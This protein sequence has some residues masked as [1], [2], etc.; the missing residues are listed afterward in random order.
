MNSYD[1]VPNQSANGMMIGFEDCIALTILGFFC[2]AIGIKGLSF[3]VDHDFGFD[4]V[5][6]LLVITKISDQSNLNSQFQTSF[7]L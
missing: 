2:W 6:I 3:E 7:I 5:A 4:L 1:Y